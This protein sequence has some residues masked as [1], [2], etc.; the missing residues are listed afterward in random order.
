MAAENGFTLVFGHSYVVGVEDV[1]L[2]LKNGSQLF[3]VRL[4]CVLKDTP[5]SFRSESYFIKDASFASYHIGEIV[6]PL[7][8]MVGDKAYCDGVVYA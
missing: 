8:H 2:K 4:H 5:T 7:F 6:T 1:N 3:G